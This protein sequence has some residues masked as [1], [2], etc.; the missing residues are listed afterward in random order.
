MARESG[1]GLG[2][3]GTWEGTEEP[4]GKDMP[5]GTS[6]RASRK[7]KEEA[8]GMGRVLKGAEWG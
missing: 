2:R 5:D 7:K 6:I 1:H 4:G 3:L 8:N